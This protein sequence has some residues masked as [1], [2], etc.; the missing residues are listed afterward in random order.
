MGVTKDQ[1]SKWQKLAAV[2][3]KE[4]EEAIN[5]PATKPSTNHIIR[6]NVKTQPIKPMDSD[7]L[8]WWGTLKDMGRDNKF[9]KSMS[10]LIAEMTPAMQA[11]MDIYLPRLIRFLD[12]YRK[13]N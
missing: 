2:P 13:E 12:E 3:E 8:W 6:A 1:S 7:A 9:S 11:D 10:E 4:F 5:R